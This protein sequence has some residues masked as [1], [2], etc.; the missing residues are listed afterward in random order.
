LTWRSGSDL[1][2][3]VQAAADTRLSAQERQQVAAWIEETI[4]TAP[5]PVRAFLALHQKYLRAGLDVRGPFDS[6]WRE[7]RRA[8][9]ITPSSERRRSG[10]PLASIPS[11][12]RRRVQSEREKLE[13]QR[14]RS[15]RLGHWHDGLNNQ[16]QG[17]VKRLEEKLAKMSTESTTKQDPE[18]DAEKELEKIQNTPVE[19]IELTEQEKAESMARTLKFV[20]HLELGAGRA[21]PALQSVNE[22]LM[23][24]GAILADEDQVFVAANLPEGFT[25]G[26][27]VKTL[28]ETRVRYD[29]TVAVTRV[30]LDVEKKVVVSEDGKRHVVSASTAQYGP[31]RYAVTWSALAT[32]AVLV[33]QFAMPFHRLATMLSTAGKR[34][35]AGGL[36][37]MLHYVAVRLVPIYLELAEQIANS[38]IL[39]GDDTTCRVVEVSSYQAEP[40]GN[41]GAQEKQRPP[42]S[43]YRTPAEADKSLRRCQEME[44]ARKQRRQDGDR[45]AK[46]TAD[47]EPSLG[48]MIGRKLEFES[49]RR[50]GAGP[51]QAM[52]VTVVSG[53]SEP[54]DPRSLIVFYRS[55]LGGY[56]DLLES[57]LR[58]RRP[59]ARDLI[60]Q[61]DLSATNLVTSPELRSR[62]RLRL[63]GCSAHA[64]RPFALYEQDDPVNCAWM[65]HL[66]KGLAIHEHRLDAHG[67]NKQNVLAVRQSESRR[68]WGQILELAKKMTNKWSKETKLG[69]AARYIV[70]HFAELTAYLDDP[71]CEPSNNMRE[72]MLRTEKLIQGSSMFR[73]TLEGRFVL[74]VVRTVLQTAVAA[75]VP[76]HAYLMSVL[77]ADA[78]EITQH[79]ERF[80]P[81]TWAAEILARQAHNEMP[82]KP[83]ASSATSV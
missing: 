21:E 74:D 14:D 45:E 78:E 12:K 6:A 59:S 47:E 52:N 46:R 75:G 63:I 73:Q 61:A 55:H 82:P 23:P 49:T 32:L 5:E 16:H 2:L 33:G 7:L 1:T 29:F 25:E 41:A 60:V 13:E 31:P 26:D 66:F 3:A 50:D 69:V 53:R 20:E 43:G 42:W 56:A 44:K 83:P 76:V 30:E 57:I 19:E 36:A 68:L 38:E 48:V 11:E 58:R 51:K 37:R 28:N 22:T 67:R 9:G 62:F 10:N 39:A 81:R 15:E 34:F 77:R 71:R 79:P 72:R 27:V 54:D 64:R 18:G 80:T 65:L 17:K 4:G 70:N 8:L 35:T 24:A 40:K